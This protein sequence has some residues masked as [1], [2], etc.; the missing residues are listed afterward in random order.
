MIQTEELIQGIRNGL[1]KWY[2]FKSGSTI[3]YFGKESDSYADVLRETAGRLVCIRQG[4]PECAE[5]AE[6][7][8]TA[9]G[10]VRGVY[11]YIV[12][13]E[14][15]EQHLEPEKLLRGWKE[16]LKPDGTLLLGMNNRFGLRYF[17]GDRDPYTERNFD[18]IEGY[19][20]AYAKQEDGFHGRCYSRAEI[21]EMLRTA[22]LHKFR[23]YSVLSDLQNPALIYAEDFLPNEDL[24]NRLFPTYNNPSTVFLEEECLYHDLIKTGMFHEMANAYLVEC[25]LDGDFSG[26]LHVTGSLE[27][28]REKAVFTLIHK[29][30]IVEKKAVYP[31]GKERLKKLIDHGRDLV[32]HGI[33]VVEAE[34][35][36]DSYVMPYIE[37]E[38]GQLYLKR[39]LRTDKEKFLQKMDDFRDLILQSSEIVREDIG[40]G[41]GVILRKGYLDMVPLNSFY[42]DG[43]FVFYDQE[44]CEENYPA[45]VLIWRMIATFYSGDMEA[46]KLLP[47]DNLLERYHLKEKLEKWQRTEWDFLIELRQERAL[48]KYH[49]RYRCNYGIINS[50]RQRLNYSAD[51][52]QR[53]FID[54][55][56]NADTRKLILFGSGNFTRQ[57]LDL[58][59]QDYPV[60][61]IVDNNKEKWGQHI[62]GIEIQPPEILCR[63]QS[64]EYKVLICI[65]NYLSVMKQLDAM[66]VREYSI[67]DSSKNYPRKRK[68]IAQ[69][70]DAD[71]KSK[72]PRRYHTGYIAGVFDLYHVGHLNMFRRA[73][74]Q[75]EYLIVGVVSDEGVRKFKH[76][77]PFV[78][79]EERIELVRACRYVDEAVEIPLN[80][81]GTRDAWRL[82]HFDCQF[83]GSD[84]ENDPGWLAE[85]EFLEEHGAEMVF[86]PYTEQ[87]NSTN[88]KAL[89]KKKLL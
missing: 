41:E 84:Y 25:P 43:T 16:L 65:K 78:P 56:Q 23:F 73:K 79:F 48:Q 32:G 70:Q 61:A 18:G 76:T 9:D 38:V 54:I 71:M 85:K 36:N 4:Q 77:D 87:T 59:Q 72:E 88:I 86:F 63:L 15:L 37:A 57:F 46:H 82:H 39:L 69:I 2:D 26:V 12:A 53:L 10:A 50:N 31:E 89:I 60:Y 14:S 3:L 11:D 55:F 13:I 58:Y 40:D 1:L 75:C 28:G 27:R 81:R 68:P 5:A 20:R 7:T 21:Q 64:G 80:F 52:Y 22:G 29:S 49:E 51:D 19:R 74:E 6:Q 33:A 34:F 67:F 45:N 42:Q 8:G 44:F 66:G 30:G 35:K 47:M 17:C 83:S 24:S 62:E